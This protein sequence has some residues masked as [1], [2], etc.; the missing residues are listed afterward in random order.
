MLRTAKIWVGDRLAGELSETGEG[1]FIFQ[2]EKSYAED[3]SAHPVSLTLPKKAELYI[4]KILFP[5]FDGLIPEGWLLE[6]GIKNWKID[7]K[8]RFGLLLHLC[9]DCIGNVSVVSN[10]EKS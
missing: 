7:P 4:S 3:D 9:Q 8:D 5:F 2:Y 6:I 10:E 1:E